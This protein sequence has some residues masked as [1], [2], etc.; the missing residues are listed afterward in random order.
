[1]T[2]PSSVFDRWVH[3][4]EEDTEHATVYRPDGYPF[5]PSRGRSGFEIEPDGTFVELS[6]APG[7]GS[8]EVPGQWSA[9]D[10]HHVRVRLENGRSY[11]LEIVEIESDDRLL[12][13]RR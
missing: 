7:D 11:T 2:L 12:K 6:I 1:M 8:A 10:D 3:S 4:H 13:V 9:P 5:P